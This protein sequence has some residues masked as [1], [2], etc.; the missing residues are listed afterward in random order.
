MSALKIGWASRCIDMDAPLNLPGQFHMRICKGSLDPL[1]TTALVLDGGEDVAILVSGDM[2]ASRDHLLDD[3]R[4]KVAKKNAAIPTDHIVYSITHTHT[5]YS[6][7]DDKVVAEHRATETSTPNAAVVPHDGMEI[8]SGTMYR[9]FLSTQIAD[10]I[11][12]AYETRTEGGIAWGY[13]YAVV[14][15]SRRVVYF[16]D[17]SQRPGA[18]RNSTHGVNGHAAMYGDTTDPMFS[19]YEAGAD[20]FINLL[21]TFDKN[22]NLTGA[23]VNIPCPSQ[24]S[25]MLEYSSADYWHD[26]REALH[27]KYGDIFILSQCA[28]AGDL[29]PRI[30]HYKKAQDRRFRLKYG[31]ERKNPDGTANTTGATPGH[32]TSGELAKCERLDIA[33]RVADAFEEVLGWAKKDI[34]W[35]VP[36]IHQVETVDLPKRIIADEEYADCLK[37]LEKLSGQDWKT[38]GTPEE[39]LYANSILQAARNRVLQIMIRYEQQ[40]TEKTFPMEM[41]TIRVGDI[42]FATN[43]FELYMDYQH[44]IQARSPFEQ[45]FVV[46]LT[47]QPGVTGGT[48]LCTER[49]AWGRGYSASMF[50]NHADY[51]AG[52]V[53]VEA[54]LDALNKLI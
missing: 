36:V 6:H 5:G 23:I 46:Q 26:V 37:E 25:E 40:K 4:A 42:A 7:Y 15:H 1:M 54:T 21:F 47:G 2:V 20:H 33:E 38:D 50:C 11:C 29:A 49:G 43:R 24:C 13:G 41:H 39:N 27:A 16:D 8:A 9:D 28:A 3:I 44:R 22:E 34:R 35:D 12:E 48:Y 45:T 19:H 17:L 14:A 52:Q 51:T 18:I 30:L 53:L 10:A 32:D 31:F